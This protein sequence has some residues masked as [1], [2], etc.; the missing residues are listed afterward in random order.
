[1]SYVPI[2]R[3]KLYELIAE[4][5]LTQISE[6][7]L[8]PGDPIPTERELTHLYRAG[9]SSVREAL[10]MLESKG[11]IEAVGGGSFTVAGLRQPAE[12]LA[13]APAQ[14]RPGDDASTSTSCAGSSSA[15]PPASQ[16]S[17]TPTS[18]S[19]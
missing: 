19:T 9:R 10:R 1:M 15:R 3:R 5:L 4:Q 13:P 6:R 7:R 18:T 12:Q 17:G 14:P 11:V 2:E 16:P 8:R